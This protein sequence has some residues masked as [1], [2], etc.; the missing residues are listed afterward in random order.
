MQPGDTAPYEMGHRS[1]HSGPVFPKG[2]LDKVQCPRAGC[3]VLSP[4]H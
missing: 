2:K 4:I 3:V 1:V